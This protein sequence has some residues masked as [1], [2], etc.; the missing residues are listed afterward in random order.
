MT[1]DTLMSV[2]VATPL[3]DMAQAKRR[4]LTQ[5][6][7]ANVSRRPLPPHPQDAS[8]SKLPSFVPTAG[9]LSKL[10]LVLTRRLMPPRG[11]MLMLKLKLRPR[12]RPLQLRSPQKMLGGSSFNFNINILPLGGIRRR[13]STKLN[14][15]SNAAV[16][17]KLGSFDSFASCR[18]GGN[19]RLETLAASCCVRLRRLAWAIS[20]DGVATGT[21]ISVSIVIK[22]LLTNVQLTALRRRAWLARDFR[23][24]VPR[25]NYWRGWLMRSPRSNT[26]LLDLIQGPLLR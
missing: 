8:E 1:M 18:C 19:G 20:P 16:G 2:P 12:S 25:E 23:L 11:R 22:V 7:A 26:H 21:L 6:L 4:N 5:Q 13:V 15:L 10:S 9:L 3:G 17:T 24:D 14:L